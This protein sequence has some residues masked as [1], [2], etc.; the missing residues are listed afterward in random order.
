MLLLFFCQNRSFT[1]RIFLAAASSCVCP[2]L[3][4]F[5]APSS[6][7]SLLPFLKALCCSCH[8][9]SKWMRPYGSKWRCHHLLPT[10]HI[11]KYIAI[12]RMA[13]PAMTY[14][15]CCIPLYQIATSGI[16]MKCHHKDIVVTVFITQYCP[17]VLLLFYD[18]LDNYIQLISSTSVFSFSVSDALCF[19]S[20]FR[21]QLRATRHYH[22]MGY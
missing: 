5:S 15:V 22:N 18:P 12:F 14:C 7:S 8:L 20:G 13:E 17:A 6:T 2:L 21:Y 11:F 3:S 10:S 9:C 1:R 19:Y 16:N 4:D